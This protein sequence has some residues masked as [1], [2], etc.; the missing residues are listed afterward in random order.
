MGDGQVAVAKSSPR[1]N[2]VLLALARVRVIWGGIVYGENPISSASVFEMRVA[3]DDLANIIMQRT[4]GQGFA[5]E[6]ACR[7][8]RREASDP[9]TAW[10][11]E[12]DDW[13]DAYDEWM[14]TQ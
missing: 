6:A 12:I 14:T 3:L 8:L 9:G 10:P 2:Q 13:A 7:A 11:A 4:W 1:D 5:F